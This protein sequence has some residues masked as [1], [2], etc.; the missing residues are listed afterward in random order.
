METAEKPIAIKVHETEKGTVVGA[1]D[2]EHLGKTLDHEEISLS[3]DFYHEKYVSV[4]EL[5]KHLEV[6]YT[7]NLFGKRAIQGYCEKNPDAKDYVIEISGIPHL[8]IYK[9]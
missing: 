3:E 7:A 1:C 4:K 6:C 9:L 5:V 2:I 8:Q